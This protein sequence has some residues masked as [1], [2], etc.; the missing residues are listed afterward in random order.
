LELRARHLETG[1]EILLVATPVIE[2]EVRPDGAAVAFLRGDSHYNMNVFLLRLAP[3]AD[4]MGL[5][6]PIGAPEPLVDGK[7]VWHVH[8]FAWDP[9]GNGFVYTRD[10][11]DGD[12]FVLER[13]A[14]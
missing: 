4:E 13:V 7:G 9:T 3:P 14:R 1:E 11:D 8:N 10:E 12:I 5:P 2:P 6:R